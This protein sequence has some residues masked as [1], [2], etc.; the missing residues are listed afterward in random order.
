[1]EYVEG[2]DDLEEEEEID[3]EDFAGF[4]TTSMP[5]YDNGGRGIPHFCY[6]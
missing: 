1:M 5:A 4:A 3:M 2:Y 6:E